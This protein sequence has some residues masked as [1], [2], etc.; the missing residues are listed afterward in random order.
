M[1]FEGLTP[2]G[3]VELNSQAISAWQNSSEYGDQFD[4]YVEA[5]L[6]VINADGSGTLYDIPSWM[7]DGISSTGPF[8]INLNPSQWTIGW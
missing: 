8:D 6:L 3:V 5:G 1:S 2:E 7:D 4:E